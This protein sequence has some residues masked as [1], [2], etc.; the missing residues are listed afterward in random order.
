M[1]IA[2]GKLLSMLNKAQ[3]IL[4]EPAAMFTVNVLTETVTER[5]V[6]LLY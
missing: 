5:T 4:D 1:L 6:D 2:E 3:V